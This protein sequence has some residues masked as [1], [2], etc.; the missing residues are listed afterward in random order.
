MGAIIVPFDTQAQ[1][2]KRLRDDMMAAYR[3]YSAVPT[4][5][6]FDRLMQALDR[7]V[8]FQ[9]R[10]RRPKCRARVGGARP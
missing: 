3:A 5:A 4:T 8:A 1:R 7:L 6:T 10:T 2:E 9:M